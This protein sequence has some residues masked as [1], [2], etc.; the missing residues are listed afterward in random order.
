MHSYGAVPAAEALQG[1]S[2][3]ERGDKGTAVV[4]MVYLSCNIPKVGDSQFGQMTVCFQ[5]L[6]LSTDLPVEASVFLN[7]VPFFLRKYS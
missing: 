6:G 7:T 4:K 3:N 2:P 1:L 5:E